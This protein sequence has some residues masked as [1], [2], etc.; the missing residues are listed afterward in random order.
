MPVAIIHVLYFQENNVDSTFKKAIY[1][2]F[3]I[4][5]YSG[6]LEE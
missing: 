4:L 3:Y 2:A 6:N 5:D 1:V